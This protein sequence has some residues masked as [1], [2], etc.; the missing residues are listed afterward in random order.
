MAASHARSMTAMPWASSTASKSPARGAVPSPKRV[1]V[2]AVRPTCTRSRGFNW[3]SEVEDERHAVA[4][5]AAEVVGD[6]RH[7]RHLS[8]PALIHRAC[9]QLGHRA[10]VVVAL[11]VVEEVEPVAEDHILRDADATHPVENLRPNGAVIFLVALFDA[12]L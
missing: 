4:T 5:L 1:T 12:G 7:R 2:T 8:L 9:C 10:V 3:G 6:G 11:D